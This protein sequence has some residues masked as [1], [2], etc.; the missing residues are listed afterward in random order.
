MLKLIKIE[1]ETSPIKRIITL[2]L[3]DKSSSATRYEYEKDLCYFFESMSQRKVTEELIKEFLEIKSCQA[4]AALIA[5][6]G[7][8]RQKQLAPATINRKISVIKSFV[9][10][11]HRLG[12]CQYSLKDIVNS[13]KSKSYRDT[14]GVTLEEFKEVLALCKLNTIKGKRDKALLML[15]WSNALRRNEISAL[16]IDDI[17]YSN[18]KLWIKSKGYNEKHAVDL[19]D[20]SIK[21]IENWLVCLNNK[22]EAHLPLFIALDSKSMGKRLSG[23]GI[24][25]IIRRYCQ[26]AGIDKRMSPHRIRHSSITTALD[27]SNG[28][29]RKVQKLSRH[30]NLNTLMIYDDNRNQDQLKLSQLLEQ[31]L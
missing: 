9:C 20:K 29:V 11:A 18:S 22:S 26:K 19:S 30:K 5:Y 17:D 21:A 25:K 8:L 4:N 1:K 28:N 14:S 27:K 31:D 7:Y 16:D 10:T 12:L 3:L 24:Y 6:K 13:E 2:W 23:D 15:L